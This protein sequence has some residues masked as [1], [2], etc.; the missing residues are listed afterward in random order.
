MNDPRSQISGEQIRREI[1]ELLGTPASVRVSIV[2]VE[3]KHSSGGTLAKLHIDINEGAR[4]IDLTLMAERL[5]MS[6]DDFSRLVLAPL[7]PTALSRP[8]PT[9]RGSHGQDE[10]EHGE[11]AHAT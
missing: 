11:E 7:F 3:S 1:L 6:L 8:Q 9:S 10:E 2:I 4:K 5:R